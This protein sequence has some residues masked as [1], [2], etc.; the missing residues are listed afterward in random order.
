MPAAARAAAARAAPA[1]AGPDGACVPRASLTQVCGS[2]AGAPCKQEDAK[3]IC[4]G[5]Q[6]AL[7]L[8]KAKTQAQ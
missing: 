6:S 5:K 1:G 3:R 4:F 8:P 2:P 7:T